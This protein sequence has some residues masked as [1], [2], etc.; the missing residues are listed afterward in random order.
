[1]PTNWAKKQWVMVYIFSDQIAN[2]YGF[3]AFVPNVETQYYEKIATGTY[4]MAMHSGSSKMRVGTSNSGEEPLS[5][6]RKML[7]FKDTAIHA[8][9]ATSLSQL[10][11][12]KYL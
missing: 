9:S 6:L 2:K 7:I 3:G 5:N 11:R 1:M 4:D 8:T 10:L 12:S